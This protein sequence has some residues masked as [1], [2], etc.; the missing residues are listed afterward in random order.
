MTDIP[1]HAPVEIGDTVVTSGASAFFPEGITVGFV[2]ALEPDRN[3]GFYNI[4]VQLAVDFNALYDVQVID[5]ALASQ[6]IC[7]ENSVAEK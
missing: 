4:G 3:G 5:D 2:E 6:R 1:E 7:L